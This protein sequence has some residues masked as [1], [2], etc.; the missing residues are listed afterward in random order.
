MVAG[1]LRTGVVDR[2]ER[3]RAYARNN[4]YPEG[5]PLD[6]ALVEVAS[7]VERGEPEERVA[8]PVSDSVA[9]KRLLRRWLDGSEP[10]PGGVAVQASSMLNAS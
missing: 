1:K 9:Q 10:L 8:G 5:S 7:A 2:L 4:G 3:L 6:Q